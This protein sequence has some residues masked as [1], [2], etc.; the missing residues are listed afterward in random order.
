M[1]QW[2]GKKKD[3]TTGQSNNALVEVYKEH[4]R[5]VR[6]TFLLL[7]DE[8]NSKGDFA[9]SVLFSQ[10]L[11]G[12]IAVCVGHEGS[13]ASRVQVALVDDLLSNE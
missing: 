1:R 4:L 2:R 5:L 8:R 9:S 3:Q 11:G 7:R 12:K 10:S 13:G 6:A